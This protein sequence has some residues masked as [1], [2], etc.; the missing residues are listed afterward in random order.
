MSNTCA[1]CG[2]SKIIPGVPL[3]DHIGDFGVRARNSRVE[4]YGDPDALVM[5]DTA[6]GELSVNICGECG[7]A[8]LYV[9]DAPAL[10]E[11][12]EKSRS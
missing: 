6:F 7:H 1:R 12:H 4:V 2:S 11:K 10:W 3:W 5:K 8:E 9:S